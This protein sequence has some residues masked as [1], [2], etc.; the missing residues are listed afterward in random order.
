[1]NTSRKA[2]S[3]LL[4]A[5]VSPVAFAQSEP[6]EPSS[7]AAASTQ[8]PAPS[9]TAAEDEAAE[10]RVQALRKFT[11][12]QRAEAVERA[13]TTFDLVDRRMRDLQ[14]RMDRDWNRMDAAARERTRG[15]MERLRAQRVE[16]AEWYGG[17]RHSSSEA[18]N[19]VRTGFADSYRDLAAAMRRAREEFDRQDTG[20]DGTDR[21]DE[22]TRDAPPAD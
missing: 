6:A 14:A 20:K 7:S 10:D 15:A 2:T 16:A 13:R 21:R 17:M 12:Q 9:A 4:L 18:W 19:D 5:L 11:F 1:M 8:S 3:L 22:S